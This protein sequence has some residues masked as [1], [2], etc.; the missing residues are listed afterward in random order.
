MGFFQ[1]WSRPPSYL[2]THKPLVPLINHKGLDKTLLRCQKLLMRLTRFHHQ[3]EHV[4]GKQTVVA[5]TLSRS[6]LKREQE[7]DTVEDVLAFV[8]LIESTCPATDTQMR[9]IKEATGRDAQLQKAMELTLQG[10]SE[11]VEE[12]PGTRVLRFSGTPVDT[13]WPSSI[14]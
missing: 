6:P 10:W 5:D 7:P 12:V 13:R 4:P 1:K 3:A 11:H 8:G 14:R 2:T 9:R